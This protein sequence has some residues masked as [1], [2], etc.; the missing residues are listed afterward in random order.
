M[1]W[2]IL[3]SNQSEVDRYIKELKIN[4]LMAKILINRNVDLNDANTII[5]NP[6]MAMQDPYLLINSEKAAIEIINAVENNSEI[7]VFA[8]YDVDGITSGF[9]MTDFLRRNTN[10]EVH[11]YYPD[12]VSGYGL[13]I[14]FCN[15]LIERKIEENIENMLIITVDNGTSCVE[16]VEFLIDNGIQVIVTDHHKP[17][18]RLPNCTVVN[19]HID[20]DDTYHHLSGVAVVYKLIQ[21]INE[22]LGCNE[23]LTSRYLYAV[24]MGT[25]ADVMPM[26]LENIAIARKGIAQLNS[27]NCPKAMKIL[28]ERIG[29][30][31]INPLDIGWEIGPRLNACGRMGDIDKAGNLFFMDE[32][33]DESEI[34]DIILEIEEMN[35]KRKSLTKRAEA[36]IAKTDFSKDRVC[37]FDATK[38]PA[39]LSGILAGRI[40]DKLKKPALVISGEE[41]LTG[42]ARSVEGIN[43]QQFLDVE[44]KNGNLVDYGGHEM[45][46]GFSLK[47][48]KLADLKINLNKKVGT[49]IDESE[50]LSFL[51]DEDKEHEIIIDSEINLGNLNK[52]VYDNVNSLPYDKDL[53]FQPT[54]YIPKLEVISTKLSKNNPNNICLTL[55]DSLG[56]KL[57]IWA[58]KMGEKYEEL[59]SPK[60]IDIAG[61]VTIHM[62]GYQYTL[63][64]SDIRECV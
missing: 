32:D 39:G 62:N 13:N 20:K 64:V 7:W 4:E 38:Y 49:F 44:K 43:L 50:K 26:N 35:E 61:N 53:F 9:V 22:T 36:D 28:K 40:S 10:N 24:A 59:G 1:K 60:F 57:D 27:K 12:R 33:N 6:D 47:Q 42:S 8:D 29:K 2:N 63:N 51:Y 5:N 23:D 34:I 16:E 21:V 41:I 58:W 37:V 30:K 55:K 46:A 52:A 15:M 56:K 54:F 25:I 14:E 19:P 31:I 45:A 3:K 18:D 48:E 11:V 17:K